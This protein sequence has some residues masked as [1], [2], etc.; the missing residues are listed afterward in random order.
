MVERHVPAVPHDIAR[1]LDRAMADDP[2]REAVVTRSR[3]LTYGELD[4]AADRA[5]HALADL[6]V[7]TGDRVAACLPN[8]A[9]VVVAFHGAMRLGA[10]WVGV[11]RA[12]APPEK[13]WQL[14]DCGASLLVTDDRLDDAGVPVVDVTAWRAAVDAAAD[15]PVDVAVDPF[16]PAGLAYTNSEGKK[17]EGP[18]ARLLRI[19]AG[20]Q[21]KWRRSS[22]DCTG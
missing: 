18:S 10:V 20:G 11:N 14:A 16:A 3:R 21:E 19:A 5:A 6:G 17:S 4:R 2:D 15:G 13:R 22:G 7:R 12:L 9:D 1:V 8:D